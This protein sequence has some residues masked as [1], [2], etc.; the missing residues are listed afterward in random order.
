MG[1][2]QS[3]EEALRPFIDASAVEAWAKNSVAETVQACIVSGRYAT[4]LAPKVYM[5]RAGVECFSGY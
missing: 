2:S 5:I 4:A 3:A 1:F